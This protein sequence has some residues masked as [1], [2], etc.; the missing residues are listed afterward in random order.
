MNPIETLRRLQDITPGGDAPADGAKVLMDLVAGI[1]PRDP[2]NA[3]TA[4]ITLQNLALHLRQVPADAERLRA[5]LLGLMATRRHVRL[6]TDTGILS[7]HGLFSTLW[8][9]FTH[10]LLPDVR[11]DDYLRDLLGEVFDRQTDHV[12]IAAIPDAIWGELID[13]ID[14][15][16]Q[17]H[18]AHRHIESEL[19]SAAHMLSTRIAAIGLDAELVRVYP[20]LEDFESPFIA[21]N[22]ELHHALTAFKAAEGPDRH[23]DDAQARVMLDQC[24]ETLERIRRLSHQTGA[25]ISLTYQLLRGNQM[26]E[27]L[28]TVLTLANPAETLQH[29]TAAL[30]LFR[31]LVREDNR[32]YSLRDVWRRA[33]DLLALQVTENASKT[34]EHYAATTR[35]EYFAMVGSA[36]GA[37]V[38]V[39]FMALIKIFMGKLALAPLWQAI[40]YS[41]NYS[42]GFMLVH[43]LHFTIATKQPAMTAAMI[44][45]TVEERSERKRAPLN[46]LVDIIAVVLRTQFVAILGNVLLAIPV[47]VAIAVTLLHWHGVPPAG[48]EKAAHLLDDINPFT[49]LALFHAAI[50]GVCL[51]LAGLVSG[52]Y[53]NKASYNR[54]PQRIRQLR[55]LRRLLGE[56]LLSRL[57]VYLGNNL[58]GLA[59]NF[60]FG[61]MLG[62]VGTLGLILGLPIDIRHVTFSAANL[63]YGVVGLDFQVPVTTVLISILGVV[64]IGLTNLAVSFS[65]AL[66]VAL[67]S[68]KVRFD[69][70]GELVRLLWARFRAQPRDFF[71]PP[72][73]VVVQPV[74]DKPVQAP[75]N[76]PPAA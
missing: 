34:G 44:A 26:I 54:I 66:L 36:A 7:H 76:P 65:L 47:S 3:S 40:A 27:R 73:D 17:K 38:I 56:K 72:K 19:V 35:R 53:D 52:Y 70:S 43:V 14:L 13:A 23:L 46:G 39:G 62:S 41:L 60:F 51:F 37:G 28:R 42:L 71:F 24:E 11:R 50:A 25:S 63:A 61:V 15:P 18:P 1:R 49:S 74:A 12:W 29:R 64:L 33:T 16:A 59:G 58:G 8:E 5:L 55:W 31:E 48:P 67:K 30:A 6:Y 32:R 4:I 22:A 10:R 9:R 21:Q 69:R 75:T 2:S 45:A 57:S 68:R 20:K